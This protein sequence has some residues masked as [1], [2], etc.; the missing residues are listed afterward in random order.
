MFSLISLSKLC[1]FV[2]KVDDGSLADVIGSRRS[3][4]DKGKDVESL[5]EKPLAV[6]RKSRTLTINEPFDVPSPP[7]GP[8]GKGKES[9]FTAPKRG[10][11]TSRKRARPEAEILLI[12]TAPETSTFDTLVVLTNCLLEVATI[13]RNELVRASTENTKDPSEEVAQFI[14]PATLRVLVSSI[15]RR[16]LIFERD[17]TRDDGAH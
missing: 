16:D 9:A 10:K 2:L 15:S 3:R 14:L 13:R 5:V 12:P 8:K 7:V 6:P 11:T 4:K 17:V 1:F